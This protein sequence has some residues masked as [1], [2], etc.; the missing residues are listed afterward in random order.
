M[1]GISCIRTIFLSGFSFAGRRYG[2]APRHVPYARR[3]ASGG[4]TFA[5]QHN[6]HRSRLVFISVWIGVNRG[7]G[8][9]ARLGFGSHGSRAVCICFS[10]RHNLDFHPLRSAVPLAPPSSRLVSIRAARSAVR[11]LDSPRSRTRSCCWTARGSYLSSRSALVHAAPLT[12]WITRNLLRFR[13]RGV[14]ATY[15]WL[16]YFTWFI[17]RCLGT[18]QRHNAV[19]TS[20]DRA[21]HWTSPPAAI[22]QHAPTCYTVP[23]SVGLHPVPLKHWVV[24]FGFFLDC[25][26]PGWFVAFWYYNNLLFRVTAPPHVLFWAPLR[27]SFLAAFRRRLPHLLPRAC[28]VLSCVLV[29]GCAIHT[30]TFLLRFRRMAD[31]S[32][33]PRLR[34][35]LFLR[36]PYS[37]AVS[38]FRFYCGYASRAAHP[39]ATVAA[40]R[41]NTL[42]PDSFARE[43]LGYRADSACTAP[44]PV[45]APVCGCAAAPSL[46]AARSFFVTYAAVLRHGSLTA[47]Q[48][49]ALSR[50]LFSALVRGTRC[51]HYKFSPFLQISSSFRALPKKTQ[52]RVIPF[53][54]REPHAPR[55]VLGV[56][57]HYPLGS[58][59][60]H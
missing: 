55:C 23:L 18:P 46:L 35:L 34:F 31:R 36:A 58:L 44:P 54:S 29:C 12:C 22:H 52:V 6:K 38:P 28:L 47:T 59:P 19:R 49:A 1:H 43:L 13:S 4:T 14:D 9:A 24:S 48:G 56:L 51:V 10:H 32:L 25:G 41:F 50:Q 33:L 15:A 42:I 26:A 27:C 20:L 39:F 40:P 45:F 8:Y 11:F 17:T 21:V 7:C 3:C 2:R 5:P 37:F 57:F 16:I 30:A 53:R 60:L